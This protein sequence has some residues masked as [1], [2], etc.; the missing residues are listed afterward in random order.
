M[1]EK[2]KNNQIIIYTGDGG[3]PVIQVRL[4]SDTVWLTQAQL[5]ELFGTTKP[6]ISIH[7]KNIFDEGEL[8]RE[9]TV[10]E[11]LTVQKEGNRDVSRKIA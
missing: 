4:G 2:A 8:M 7:V 10:K 11:Y 3:E 1:N 5:A 9:G 6:N